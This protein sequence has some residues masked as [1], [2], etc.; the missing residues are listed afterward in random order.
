M[1][2][3][4]SYAKEDKA[5]AES[6]AF[7][8]RN[9]GHKVFLDRDDLPAG[10]S[11]D[12]QIEKAIKASDA[13]V[14]LVSPDSIAE[15]RFTMTELVFARQKWPAPHGRV[16]PVVV[17]KTDIALVPSYLKA[18]TLLEPQG[19]VVAETSAAVDA[20]GSGE[21]AK[22]MALRFAAAGALAGLIGA[23]LPYR[24]QSMFGFHI[25]GYAL[26]VGVAMALAMAAAFFVFAGLKSTKSLVTVGVV[27]LA[28][29]VVTPHVPDWL[30]STGEASARLTASDLDNEE[31]AQKLDPETLERLKQS[32]SAADRAA[33]IAGSSDQVLRFGITGVL[34]GVALLLGLSQ[35]TAFDFRRTD[36]IRAAIA[37]AL[38][39]L[40]F[41]IIAFMFEKGAQ[42]TSIV[43]LNGTNIEF[44]SL[45][46]WPWLIAA[47]IA[48][49]STTW[50]AIGYWVGRH[51]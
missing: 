5:I 26:D 12:Q 21:A 45:H 33:R 29:W 4:L 41:G 32:V 44:F 11:F 36:I 48:W 6:L 35:A 14:F 51:T 42:D 16:F 23:F 9:R 27:L 19:N 18:V 34:F 49:L 1:Q 22:T 43:I 13:V 31:L 50:A 25:F 39:G 40:L 2:L 28:L 17:R 15:G 38:G 3:F 37:G 20:L 46:S 10:E 8:L 7:S 30:P 24:G 47:M